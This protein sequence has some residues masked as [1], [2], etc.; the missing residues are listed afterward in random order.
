MNSVTLASNRLMSMFSYLSSFSALFSFLFMFQ[1]DKSLTSGFYVSP[2]SI[3][4]AV[5]IFGDGGS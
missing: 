5:V 3:L 2:T 1:L 4:F